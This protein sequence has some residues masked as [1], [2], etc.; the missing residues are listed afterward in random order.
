[1]AVECGIE[2]GTAALRKNRPNIPEEQSRKAANMMGGTLAKA[3]EITRG[4]PV[5]WLWAER[6]REW[7]DDKKRDAI[8]DRIRHTCRSNGLPPPKD[9]DLE[10]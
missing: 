1:L 8:R 4:D 3:F 6:Q 9:E 10:W 7:S 5:F 2:V